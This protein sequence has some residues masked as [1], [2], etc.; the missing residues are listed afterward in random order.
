MSS[1]IREIELA[2]TLAGRPDVI[3]VDRSPL[4]SHGEAR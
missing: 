2:R 1:A 4:V 3:A